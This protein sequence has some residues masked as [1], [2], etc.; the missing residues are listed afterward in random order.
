MT[1]QPNSHEFT[2]TQG[3][4]RFALALA[5]VTGVLTVL[6]FGRGAAQ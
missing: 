1:W 3:F 4:V 2:T 6:T 5:F